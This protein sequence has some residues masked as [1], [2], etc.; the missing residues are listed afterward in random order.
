MA[1]GALGVGAL[2]SGGSALLQGIF[3]GV[4]AAKGNKGFNRA[5]ANRPTYE[6]PDEYKNILAQYQQAQAGNMPGYE[7][8]LSQIGQSGARARGAAERGA[9]SS[10]SYGAQVGDLYQKELDAIQGLGIKQEEYKTS[11]MDRVA[12]AQGQMGAQ[13]SEQ[14]NINKFMPW[15][16]EMNRF[17]EQKQA[18]IQNMFSGLQSGIG[19]LAD[20]AGT[21]YYSDALAKLQNVG[22]ASPIGGLKSNPL[23]NNYNPQQN[24]FNTTSDLLKKTKI[25]FPQ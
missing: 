11:M 17:G 2:L 8:T 10:A 14:W 5:M 9:I 6:I 21:K 22:G 19:N 7:Q 23:S 15:Q 20:L 25:N 18:G 3:G 1:I 16:T 13:K 12:Q 24:L 4:Q